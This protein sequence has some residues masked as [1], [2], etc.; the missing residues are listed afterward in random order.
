[1]NLLWLKTSLEFLPVK[2][3]IKNTLKIGLTQVFGYNADK[4]FF[5]PVTR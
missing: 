5:W 3:F 1:M 2:L 4:N